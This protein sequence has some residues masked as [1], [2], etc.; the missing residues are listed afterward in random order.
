MKDKETQYSAHAVGTNW[1]RWVCERIRVTGPCI[2]IQ[3][4]LGDF[5]IF[6][7]TCYKEH[8]SRNASA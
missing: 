4:T 2:N 3:F 1:D 8:L 7:Y 6:K 5:K